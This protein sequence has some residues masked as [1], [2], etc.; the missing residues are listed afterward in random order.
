MCRSYGLNNEPKSQNLPLPRQSAHMTPKRLH[1]AFKRSA[2]P[3]KRKN[4]Q[5]FACREMCEARRE[6]PFDGLSARIFVRR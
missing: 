3:E 4:Q 1:R 6:E 2:G 5:V